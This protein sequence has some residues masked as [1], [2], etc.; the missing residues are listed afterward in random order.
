MNADKVREA[1]KQL[2]ETKDDTALEL[3]LGMRDQAIAKDPS[4]KVDPYLAPKYDGTV[5]GPIDTIRD[6]G[7]R[8]AKRWSQE[9]HGLVCGEKAKDTKE[10][11]EL[12]SA[13]NLG[14]AAV[15]A[16]V[17]SALLALG[18]AGAI[19]AAAAPLIVRRFIWPAKDELCT[20]WAES[21]QDD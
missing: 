16:A 18:L 15:I 7:K 17:A 14:E 1:A 11:R 4:K 10:R 5:M 19:A 2:A 13:L 12:L 21:L 20:A 3:L 9:L 6:L 8:I